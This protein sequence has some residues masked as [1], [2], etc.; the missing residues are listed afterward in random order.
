MYQVVSVIGG[1]KQSIIYWDLST[2]MM[3]YSAD[4]TFSQFM[5]LRR[6]RLY[7]TDLLDTQIT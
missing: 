5:Q 1:N 4:I 3:S 2:L 7:L 6:Q